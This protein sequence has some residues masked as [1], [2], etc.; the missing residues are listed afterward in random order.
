[1]HTTHSISAGSPW[2]RARASE[3]LLEVGDTPPVPRD[4]RWK[5][6]SAQLELLHAQGRR[7]VRIIDVNCGDG[8][9]LVAAAHH[10][11]KLGFLAIEGLGAA[12]DLSLVDEARRLA[13]AYANPAIGLTFEQAEPLSRLQA[14]AEFPADIV[15][16]ERPERR[17]KKFENAL[18]CAGEIALRAP[19]ARREPAR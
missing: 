17:S 3:H 15:L 4:R 10:A 19:R 14:E 1:M 2:A 18:K 7:A 5:P 9:L 11:R 13:R 8:A 16:F 6:L 12:R